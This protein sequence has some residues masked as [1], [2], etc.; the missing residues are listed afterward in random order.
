VVDEVQRTSCPG[1]FAAGDSTPVTYKQTVIAAGQG[2]VAALECY[3]YL[4]SP[5]ETVKDWAQTTK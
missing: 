4:T 1:L 2:A 3:K 5:K